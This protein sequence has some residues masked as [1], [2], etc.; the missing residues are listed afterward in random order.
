MRILIIGGGGVTEELLKSV[1]LKRTQV[2]VIEKDPNKC[3]EI[4][5]R[6]DV[7]V[8]NKDATDISVYTSDISMVELDGVLALTNK[9]EVNVFALT[10]AKLYNIP[11][12]LARVRSPKI[13]ELIMRLNLGVP[14]TVPS[15]IADLVKGYLESIGEPVLVTEFGDFKIMKITLSETDKAV[16]KDLKEL[17]LPSDIKVLLIFDGTSLKAPTDSIKFM[18]GYQVFV[19]APKTEDVIRLFKG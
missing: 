13:A 6:Y 8:I 15:I 19:A 10:I 17:E 1:N 3:A 14:I 2:V 12:R 11:M 18:N 4:G 5:S 7:L 16:G 9:D